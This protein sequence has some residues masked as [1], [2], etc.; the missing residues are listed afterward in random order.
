MGHGRDPE[1]V[2]SHLMP[3]KRNGGR[4][5]F[6]S[7]WR[8][9]GAVGIPSYIVPI[10]HLQVDH[11]PLFAFA[12]KAVTALFLISFLFPVNCSCSQSLPFVSPVLL[13]T[14]P[15]GG[16]GGSDRVVQGLEWFQWEH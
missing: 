9:L 16:G 11:S 14:L 3:F 4:D 6:G 10:W 13:S 15:E 5:S 8:W 1:V 2:L 12:I 7:A